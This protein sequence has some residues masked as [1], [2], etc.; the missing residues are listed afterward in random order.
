MSGATNSCIAG[1]ILKDADRVFR[2]VKPAMTRLW[3]VTEQET[4]FKWE[5]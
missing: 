1:H 2:G 5:I 4:G 3:E